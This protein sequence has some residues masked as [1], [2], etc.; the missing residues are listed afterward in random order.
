[1]P[2]KLHYLMRRLLAAAGLLLLISSLTSAWGPG[3]ANRFC[4]DAVETIW[5]TTEAI[6]CLTLKADQT[7][8]FCRMFTQDNQTYEK[9]KTKTNS[10]DYFILPYAPQII[11]NDTNTRFDY[12]TCPIRIQPV[13]KFVCGQANVSG[14][15]EKAEEWFAVAENQ[16]TLCLRVQAYCIGVN[17]LADA[18]LP[19]YQTKVR[20]F[21]C[22]RL[23]DERIDLDVLSTPE[24]WRES[25]NCLYR[26]MIEHIGPDQKATYGQS[27]V[28][29]RH[30]YE[31]ALNASV[32]AG[33]PLK[34]I[35]Y[36]GNLTAPITPPA[37]ENITLNVS[38]Q[39]ASQTTTQNNT[40]PKP[41]PNGGGGISVLLILLAA[42]VVAV[43]VV[44]AIFLYLR[45]KV[46]IEHTTLGGTK[47]ID[48]ETHL[49]IGL[50]LPTKQLP[51]K[52]LRNV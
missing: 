52:S 3:A 50:H 8:A 38:N 9:C 24:D 48:K 30:I 27:Y 39:N 4:F 19:T 33:K 26:Y 31:E 23:L 20:D 35:K 11:L 40:T 32:N 46:A 37:Q 41:K 2:K 16:P 6:N 44:A 28:V 34:Y 29:S 18:Y 42:A 12:T 22:L 14:L 21:E 25:T 43:F 1:M 36:S 15:R 10:P 7:E 45:N 51:P 47:I 17:Y 49:P 13:R 5:N